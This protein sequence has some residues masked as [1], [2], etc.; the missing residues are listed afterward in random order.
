MRTYG[1]ECTWCIKE[2]TLTVHFS[3]PVGVAQSVGDVVEVVVGE[4]KHLE[5]GAEQQDVHVEVQLQLLAVVLHGNHAG[6]RHPEPSRD[7][8]GLERGT[9][10]NVERGELRPH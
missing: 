5:D 9:L 8:L 2:T 10:G 1:P 7:L 4:A 3:L 6:Q